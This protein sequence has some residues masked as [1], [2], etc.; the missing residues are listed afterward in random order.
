[1][2][3]A[4]VK[5]I[6]DC[7]PKGKTRFYYFKDRY[8]LLLL[9]LIVDG[10]T[11]KK[12][13]RRSSFSNLL[14]KEL[15][16]E[17]IKRSRGSRLS[18]ETFE[19]FWP[20]R[21]ECYFLTL[22]IWGSKRGYWQQTSR[23]GYNLVLQLNFS[24]AHDEP[25]RKLIDPEDERPF[26]FYSHPIAR[27]S[28]HTLAW[29]RLDI[30]LRRGE[31]LI[32]ELQTDWIRDALD[33]RRRAI[34][35]SD[36]IDFYGVEMQK[37][38][39]I[40]Y[41]DSVLHRHQETWDEAML[42]AT[43]WFLRKELGVRTIFYH[44]YESGARLKGISVRLPPRSVYSRLPKRFCFKPTDERP[45]FLPARARASR[46]NPRYDSA[47]FSLLDFEASRLHSH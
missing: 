29:S 42:S 45:A 11:S 41:V 28:M 20:S 35:A 10:E 47:R 22:G 12:S 37:D 16:K 26:S 30:D 9:S 8:A 40:R 25:Y 46:A 24:S 2:D 34:R 32:E 1:M 38:R 44:T 31:A 43:I 14:D 19:G 17:A 18:A 21:Y 5:E 13:L 39:V 33:A 27:N 7:L 3:L 23:P 6:I 4:D 15:V 36:T